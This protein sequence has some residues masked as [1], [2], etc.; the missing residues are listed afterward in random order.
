[1]TYATNLLNYSSN[2]NYLYENRHIGFGHII[3]TSTDL[4]ELLHKGLNVSKTEAK[5]WITAG[6][7]KKQL[8]DGTYTKLT[9]LEETDFTPFITKEG[10][11]KSACTLKIGKQGKV[12]VIFD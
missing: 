7:V 8:V 1:M 9:E 2:L 3:S 6:S 5:R 12:L 11:T 4:L 10:E